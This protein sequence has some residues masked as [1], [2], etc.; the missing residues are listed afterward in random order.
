MATAV[1]PTFFQLDFPAVCSPQ[2]ERERQGGS[3]SWSWGTLQIQVKDNGT[4]SEGLR[5]DSW[6]LSSRI[7]AQE[8]S[9]LA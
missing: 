8:A 2:P 1:G 7:P 9:V 4:Y 3:G 5:F 6:G